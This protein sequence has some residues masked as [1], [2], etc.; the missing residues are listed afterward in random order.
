VCGEESLHVRE[1][2]L[3]RCGL[4]RNRSVH[5]DLSGLGGDDAGRVDPQER[6]TRPALAALHAFEQE[7]VR[8]RVEFQHRTDRRL[9]VG[10]HFA[11]HGYDGVSLR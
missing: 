5:G 7:T 4:L 3:A 1:R 10:E 11:P 8:T 9:E 2:R 6:I